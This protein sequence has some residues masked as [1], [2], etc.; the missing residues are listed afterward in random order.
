MDE[1][2]DGGVDR[3]RGGCWMHGGVGGW[4]DERVDAWRGE[5]MEG[6]MDGRVDESAKHTKWAICCHISF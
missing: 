6:W 5:W 1:W 3:W 2:M 4:M